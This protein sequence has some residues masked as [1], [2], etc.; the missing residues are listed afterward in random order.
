MAGLIFLVPRITVFVL[1]LSSGLRSWLTASATEK[2]DEGPDAHGDWQSRE[3]VAADQV[4]ALPQGNAGALLLDQLRQQYGGNPAAADILAHPENYPDDLLALL[5]KRPET[6]DFVRNYPQKKNVKEQ[7]DLSGE[8]GEGIVP[9]LYQWDG[10]WGYDRYGDSIVALSGC[11]PTCLSMVALGLTKD[12]SADPGTVAALSE[13]NGYVTEVGTSWD[14]MTLGAKQLGL[15]GVEL[16][17]DEGRMA[18][19]LSEGCPIICSMRPGD[20]TDTGHFIVL[21]GYEEGAFTVND[22]NSI[23]NSEKRWTYDEIQGQ[24]KNLWAYSCAK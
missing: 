4:A 23:D 11:G 21:T 20:F 1:D 6:L 5:L 15:S 18:Q 22:P 7:V 3:T 13:K 9:R 17:L 14:L 19:A 12:T 10:R 16:P 2:T 8:I 24:I